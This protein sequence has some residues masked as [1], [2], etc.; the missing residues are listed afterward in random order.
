MQLNFYELYKQSCE[1]VVLK[2][3]GKLK[4]SVFD[5]KRNGYLRYVTLVSNEKGYKKDTIWH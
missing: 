4:W 5:T 2:Q 1:E 3:E